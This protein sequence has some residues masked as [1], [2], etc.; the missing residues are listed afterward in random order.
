MIVLI[1][2]AT[3]KAE[4]IMRAMIQMFEFI[5]KG[6]CH[7]RVKKGNEICP[8]DKLVESSAVANYLQC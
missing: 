5:G 6:L 3:A 8:R 4:M 7:L 1:C 2:F